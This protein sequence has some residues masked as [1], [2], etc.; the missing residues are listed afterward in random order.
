[1]NEKIKNF[2]N[3]YGTLIFAILSL[4]IPFIIYILTLERKLVGGDTTWYALYLPKMQVMVP[5]GYPTFSMLGKLFTFLPFGDIAYRLN[6]LSAVFGAST[7]LLLFLAINKIIKNAF[8]SFAAA[9]T[10]AFSYTYWTIANRLEFDTINSF[11][12]A[13]ILYS[14]FLYA[15]KKQRKHF[16]LF[17]AALGLSLTNH[18]ITFF[19]MPA[20]LLYVILE[21]PK[22]FKSAKAVL[23]GILFFLMPLSLYAWLPIRSMQGYGPVTSARG[24]LYY[25]TGRNVGGRVHGGSFQDK[26][27]ENFLKVSRDFFTAIYENFGI[28]LL[29]IAFAGLIYLFIKKWKFALSS[30]VLIIF[31]IIIISLYLPFSP[32]NYSLNAMMIISIYLAFGFLLIFNLLMRVFEI[33]KINLP[34]SNLQPAAGLNKKL[35][36]K[37]LTALLLILLFMVSPVFMAVKNYKRADYSKPLGIYVYWSKIFDH[38]QDN[39]VI[40]VSSSASNIGEFI[41]TYERRD[42]NITFITNRDKKYNEE[43]VR[44]NIADGKKIYF[45]G[46]EKEL[47]AVFNVKK[48][49]GYYWERMDEY[50]VFYDFAGEKKELKIIPYFDI[51]KLGFG[52]KFEIEYKIINENDTDIEVSS[53]ELELSQN[54][55]FAGVGS[56]GSINLEPSLS[57]GKY[58]WVKTFPV[59]ANSIINIILLLQ[60]A[61]P[62]KAEIDFSITSQDYYFKADLVELDIS[63]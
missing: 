47:I 32:P 41:N 44:A 39:A 54:I 18:P 37:N 7:I 30:V 5:T 43:N 12:I 60:A 15:E 8:I 38:M 29:A 26:D 34:G 31:N 1:M 6:L 9:L 20:F 63:N 52:D 36:L 14:A 46:I 16:Y 25:V 62:G 24:F 11:F 17:A 56:S 58:M 48:I 49:D 23:I 40:Y 53:L 59:M 61:S 55:S 42:K 45:V 13:L 3:R 19:I 33:S 35:L 10:F 22:M 21:N 27:F 28:I 57:Q 4:L 2:Y 50:I 51:D